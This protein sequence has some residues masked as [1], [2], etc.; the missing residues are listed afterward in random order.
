[1]LQFPPLAP[2]VAQP[3][4]VNAV[5]PDQDLQVTVVIPV[6]NEEDNI[7]ALLG[8]LGGALDGLRAEILIV[9]D[10]DDETAGAI[11]RSAPDCP[12]AVKLLTR[13]LG[14]RRGGLSGAVI[15]GARYATGDWVLVM[16]GDLQHPPQAAAGLVAAALRHDSDIVVGTRYAGA[17]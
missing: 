8:G 15:A 17:G 16:D 11:A 5:V 6:R 2:D 7:D 3:L 9:D 13:P 14:Q 10:S 1:M 4:P 12:V